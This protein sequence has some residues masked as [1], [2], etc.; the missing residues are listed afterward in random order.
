MPKILSIVPENEIIFT[1]PSGK[2]LENKS[3]IYLLAQYIGATVNADDISR[4]QAFS[5][6]E[7]MNDLVLIINRNNLTFLADHVFEKNTS[8]D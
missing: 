8:A 7:K 2:I 4:A 1:L 5:L 3:I 6:E